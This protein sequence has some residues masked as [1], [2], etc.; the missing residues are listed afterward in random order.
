[1]FNKHLFIAMAEDHSIQAANILAR[2]NKAHDETLKFIS[3][4]EIKAKDRVDIPLAEY[5]RLKEENEYLRRENRS[6][7]LTLG[8][9][10]IPP[11]IMDRIIPSSVKCESCKSLRDFIT[12]YCIQFNIEDCSLR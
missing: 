2:S 5:E 12:H 1:M 3:E 6:L 11:E 9:I 4:K 7:K 8:N 10:G